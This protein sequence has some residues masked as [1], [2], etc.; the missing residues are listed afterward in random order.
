LEELLGE[1]LEESEE[2]KEEKKSETNFL[3]IKY[4]KLILFS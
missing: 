3:E 4:T 1:L 2:G